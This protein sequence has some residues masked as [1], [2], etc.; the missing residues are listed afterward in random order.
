[1]R[2]QHNIAAL[3]SYRNLTNNNNA[4]SKNLERLSSGYR[5]NRAGDDAAGL[6]ISE[7]MRAQITGLETAQKNANDGISLVQTAEGALTEVHSMLNRMVELANQSANGTYADEVDR[8]NLQAEIESLT[9]EIDRIADSTN[10]NGINLLDGSMSGGTVLTPKTSLK[11][12]DLPPVA[13]DG[14]TPVQDV[15]TVLHK[16]GISE[17]TKTAFSVDFGSVTLAKGDKMV[18]QIGDSKEYL[19]DNSDGTADLTGSTLNTKVVEALNGKFELS[20]QKFTVSA[21]GGAVKFEQSVPPTKSE[22]VVSANQQVKITSIG[23]AKLTAAD[24]TEPTVKTVSYTEGSGTAEAKAVLDVKGAAFKREGTVTVAI[25][26]KNYDV[27][28]TRGMTDKEF[29]TAL[30]GALNADK[31]KDTAAGEFTAVVTDNTKITLTSANKAAATDTDFATNM[32]NPITVAPKV[33]TTSNAAAIATVTPTEGTPG[34]KAV[35]TID[36]SGKTPAANK[37]I[38]YN[39]V[40]Y[41]TGSTTLADEVEGFANALKN[42]AATSALYDVAVQ[43]SK[44]VLTAKE[45]GTDSNATAMTTAI[46]GSADAFTTAITPVATVAG[47]DTKTA[48]EV[49]IDFSGK[50]GKNVIGY[51]MEIGGQKFQ[52]VET[53]KSSTAESGYT[54]VEVEKGAN[55]STIAGA[56]NTAIGNKITGFTSATEGNGV[57]LTEGTPAGDTAAPTVIQKKAAEAAE[58]QDGAKFDFNFGTIV[59]TQG[60]VKADNRYAS[61]RFT[62]KKEMLTDGATMKIGDD[63]Y[64]FAVGKDSDYKSSANVVDLTGYTGKEADFIDKAGEKL[65]QA[66]AGN[67][68]FTV[69]YQAASDKLTFME[70]MDYD[71]DDLDTLDGILSKF[72]FTTVPK[73][74]QSLTLQIG[75]TSQSFNKL[76]VSVSDMHTNAMG[77]GD[78]DIS[79]QS[80]AAAAVD[81]IKEAINYV[82]E[83]RGQLGAI[84]NRL[85][86]TINNL[87][88]TAENITAAESRIRDVDMA[89]EMMAYT[90]NNILVQASQAML[91]QA[92]QIPQGVLQLLQ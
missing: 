75:D 84:Q 23:T 57:K 4:V 39:G 78:I 18:V 92:N 37:A 56:L 55:A 70:K 32:A 50:V 81:K 3:N 16:E 38:T 63:V 30:A 52:F 65:T 83:S 85:E 8:D 66:A 44:I 90:K 89:E 82:S 12:S 74:G 14:Q 54:A 15:N 21:S 6:A 86:H 62:L 9:A 58:T 49:K 72:E 20:G 43:G 22:E 48:A 40:S 73:I 79:T 41:T 59:N 61:T 64:T 24:I 2:I 88:V 47:N 53:G 1:M 29:A 91:A 10:F 80:G 28:V 11:A 77:I 35:Y 67:G 46:T 13:A 19:I 42:D 31:L 51:Q 45:G 17:N 68:T 71:K 26:G 69:G 87:S 36:L 33:S 5:I 7:K 25:G 34:A 76:T 27:D 60:G